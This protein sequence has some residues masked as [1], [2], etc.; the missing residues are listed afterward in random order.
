MVV[1]FDLDGTIVDDATQIIPDSAV[2]AV[3]ELGRRGH[4]AVVNTGRPYGHVD[5]RIRQMAFAGW[6]CGCGME[7]LLE[8][9]WLHRAA[10]RPEVCLSTV[11]AVRSCGMQV[12]YEDSDRMF[13]DGIYSDA[14]RPM[15]QAQRLRDRGV[16]VEE[17]TD[18]PAPKF[19]K[20]ITHD[21]PGCR[22][23]EFLERTAPHFTPIDRGRGMIEY[24]LRGCSK[25]EGMNILLRHLRLG[26]ED[27][28][29]IGDSTNDL[30]MFDAAG[31]TVCM[32]SGM[33]ELK[34]K[35]D[36]IT[37]GVLDDGIEK[38]LKH[39]GLI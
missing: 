8:G 36:Y 27:A 38:A 21:A 23:A 25:A 15:R 35:A 28:L 6:I 1:F 13:R 11:E 37:A 31:H 18:Q 20:F 12:L 33:D 9:K 4:L 32:G 24:V 16:P 7:V 14:P 39:Y 3:E 29:A 22:R 10:P 5:P 2:R 19:I 34:E 30:P 26:K 17:I